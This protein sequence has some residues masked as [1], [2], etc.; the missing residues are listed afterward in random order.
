MPLTCCVG[1]RPAWR[2]RNRA[3]TQRLHCPG[4]SRILLSLDFQHGGVGRTSRCTSKSIG[5]RP[6]VLRRLFS[7]PID[8]GSRPSRLSNISRVRLPPPSSTPSAGDVLAEVLVRAVASQHVGRP[9]AAEAAMV[10]VLRGTGRI[11]RRQI[12]ERR[13][14]AGRVEIIPERHSLSPQHGLW[15]AGD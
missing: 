7:G 10:A 14:N 11:V 5:G 8:R 2:A 9:H 6:G 1:S 4:L 13:R 15:A 3:R 12:V